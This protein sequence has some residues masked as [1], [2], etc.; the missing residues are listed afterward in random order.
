MPIRKFSKSPG[1]I[2][3][4][5]LNPPFQKGEAV[6]MPELVVLLKGY[7]KTLASCLNPL[8]IFSLI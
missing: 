3:K 8:T 7:A 4:I 2:R 1:Y 5:P 6:G